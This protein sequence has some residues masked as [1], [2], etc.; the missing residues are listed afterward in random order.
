MLL[1]TSIM[2]ASV[3]MVTYAAAS[4]SYS[5]TMNYRLV[6]GSKNKQYYTLNGGRIYISGSHH[7]YST[8]K[9]ALK[10]YNNIYYALY[11]K[12][13]GADYY[14]GKIICSIKDSPSG[15]IGIGDKTSSKYYLQIYKVE[16]DGHNIKGSG[17]LKNR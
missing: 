13:A 1:A 11:R 16:D 12:R 9:G 17:R 6:D 7:E 5:Y 10:T 4:S 2:M 14:C 8:D 3:G 15:I